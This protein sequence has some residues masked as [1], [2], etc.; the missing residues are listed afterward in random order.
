MGE[1]RGEEGCTGGGG[2][3]EDGAFVGVV[4]VEEGGIGGGG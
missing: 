3:C 1:G 4:V 2:V